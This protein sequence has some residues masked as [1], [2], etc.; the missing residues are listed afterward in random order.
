MNLVYKNTTADNVAEKYRLK[1]LVSKSKV[2]GWKAIVDA[3]RT[4]PGFEDSDSAEGGGL[5]D[6][7]RSGNWLGGREGGWDDKND[8]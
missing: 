6:L 3:I 4:V 8:Y 1:Y 7:D 5:A 2:L